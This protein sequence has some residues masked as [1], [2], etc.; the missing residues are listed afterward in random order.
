MTVSPTRQPDRRLATILSAGVVSRARLLG[1]DE[2]ATLRQLTG[3]LALLTDLVA[4]HA[5]Q[6]ASAASDGL[7]AEFPSE[8]GQ[9]PDDAAWAAADAA[10]RRY[11]AEPWCS[12]QQGASSEDADSLINAP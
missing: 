9:P 2:I 1:L 11:Y 7:L 5:G 10:R 4:R 6:V 12:A 3:H 8:L